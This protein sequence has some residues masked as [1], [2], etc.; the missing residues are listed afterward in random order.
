MATFFVSLVVFI[1]FSLLIHFIGTITG[2]DGVFGIPVNVFF[3]I[4]A[5]SVYLTIAAFF[6]Y[7]ALRFKEN[8]EQFEKLVKQRDRVHELI[9]ALKKEKRDGH[10]EEWDYSKY[11][12]EYTNLLKG[13]DRALSIREK[14]LKGIITKTPIT[15]MDK[16]KFMIVNLFSTPK[17]KIPKE[18]TLKKLPKSDLEK[19]YNLVLLLE[20]YKK[21][22]GPK[23]V[24]Q[25]IMEE[26]YSEAIAKKVVQIIY[27]KPIKAGKV[28]V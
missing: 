6:F 9:G 1:V 16:A 23:E 5:V 19:I 27:S 14:K 7:V 2:I 24:R 21:L 3:G 25:A 26:G 20:P 11:M 4:Y 17:V 18:G 8:A 13:I 22:Y 12:H 10:V 28:G 15:S